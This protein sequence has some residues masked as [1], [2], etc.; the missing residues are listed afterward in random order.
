VALLSSA[1]TLKVSIN[2]SRFENTT[3]AGS[4]EA[5]GHGVFAQQR[6]K[7]TIRD[8]VATGNAGAG[9]YAAASGA[10]LT[11]EDSESSNNRDGVIASD[12]FGVGAGAV[13]V[14]NTVVTH[15]SGIGFYQ[16]GAG[17]FNSL[18]NNNVRRNGTNTTGTI[19]VVSGT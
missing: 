13:T 5:F 7:V 6:S 9:F 4:L 16:L 18:G 14:S 17:V 19:N 2:R 1:G 10:D 15:N 3:N 11:I 12:H 8:S